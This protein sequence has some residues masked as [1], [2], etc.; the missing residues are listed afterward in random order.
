MIALLIA[1]A[2]KLDCAAWKSDCVGIVV[3]AMHDRDFR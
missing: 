2:R 1:I 3:I